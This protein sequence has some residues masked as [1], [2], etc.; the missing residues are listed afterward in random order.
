[1]LVYVRLLSSHPCFPCCPLQLQPLDPVS[2]LPKG[3][4]LSS[5][6]DETF[7]FNADVCQSGGSTQF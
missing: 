3:A 1:M 5:T 4:S 6:F 7:F 2:A